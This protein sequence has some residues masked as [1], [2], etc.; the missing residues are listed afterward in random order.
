MPKIPYAGPVVQHLRYLA[1]PV[2]RENY[3]KYAYP[4]G[5]PEPLSGEE[6]AIMEEALSKGALPEGYDEEGL[7]ESIA[8]EKHRYSQMPRGG[9]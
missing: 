5:A 7:A 6:Q 1:L 8:F 2:T 9:L 3:L 4:E